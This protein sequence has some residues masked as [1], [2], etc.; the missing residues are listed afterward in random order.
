MVRVYSEARDATEDE[1][2]EFEEYAIPAV[3]PS[4]NPPDGSIAHELLFL[5]SIAP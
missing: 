3:D 2:D 4:W 5:P 1:I